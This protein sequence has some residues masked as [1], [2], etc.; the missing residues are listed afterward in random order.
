MEYGN[1]RFADALKVAAALGL[2]F[3]GISLLFVAKDIFIT[4]ATAI[5]FAIA[6]DKPIDKLVKRRVPRIL[7]GIVIY[8][9]LLLVLAFLLYQFLPPLAQEIRYFALSF[10]LFLERF[11]DFNKAVSL[12]GPETIDI[13]QY[14]RTVSDFLGASSQTVVGTIFTI[15][16]GFISFIVIF[17][18]ALFLNIQDNGVRQFMF[19]LV[20]SKH[21]DYANAFFNKTQDRVT[22]WLWGKAL[23][24]LIV[25]LITYLGLV[26][27]GIPFALTLSVL[28][29]F[30]NFIPFAGPMIASVPAI[31]LGFSISWP[32]GL[33]VAVLYFVVNS[34]IEGFVLM[35]IFMKRAVRVSPVLLILFVLL[36]GRLAGILGIIISIPVAAVASLVLEESLSK[37]EIPSKETAT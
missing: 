34:I 17:F 30:L 7:A 21:L 25:G 15:F 12:S 11:F 37:K 6:F 32:H 35:P 24:S 8:L 28:I 19:F 26:I 9:G 29:V 33:A 4:F 3:L 31:L 18:V 14:L 16:G 27:L 5:I 2:I 1:L 22:G 36:G 20:P 10:P 13:S 23:S